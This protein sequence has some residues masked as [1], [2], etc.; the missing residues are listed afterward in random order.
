MSQEIIATGNS[1]AAL[2]AKMAKV[3]VISAY[4]I[5]PQT[6]IVEILSEWIERDAY[7]VKARYVRVESE[8]SAL[9]VVT[10]ASATGARTFTAT[11]S[12]G[13]A[14]MHEV[15][16][17]VGGGRLPIVMAVVNRALGPPWNV[18][19]DHTDSLSQRNTG[20]IQ[21]YADNNQEVF[22][23]IIQAYRICEDSDVLL[24]AM[25][26]LDAFILSHTVMPFSIPSQ[27]AIDSFLP[28]YNPEH[29]Y[30]D[31]SRP[32][33]LYPMVFPESD[34]GYPGFMDFQYLR[35]K[36]MENARIKINEVDKE[37]EKHFGRSHGGMIQPYKCENAETLILSMGTLASESK[38]VVD[39]LREQGYKVGSVKIRLFRPFPNEELRDVSMGKQTLVVIDRNISFGNEGCLFTEVKGALYNLKQRPEIFGF[40]AGLGGRDV[41]QMHIEKFV[42]GSIIATEKGEVQ[43]KTEWIGLR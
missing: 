23:T 29:V 9:A 4:P 1:A 32:A 17:W 6:S 25:I 21:F 37:F 12:H 5:T 28:S 24:P 8:H 15:L 11:S 42:K 34:P 13:L 10:A 2:A 18:W 19:A 36:A 35:H 33:V 39:S 27:E 43:E 3:Q 7:P 20:W 16:H 22:D 38:I 31:P 26:C 30:L 14:L 40:V 41:T